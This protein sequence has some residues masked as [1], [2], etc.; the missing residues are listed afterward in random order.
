[1]VS[2]FKN[3][4]PGIFN[5]TVG[6]LSTGFRHDK[7]WVYSH[8]HITIDSFVLKIQ[9]RSQLV[10][11]RLY[12]CFIEHSKALKS[13]QI[14]MSVISSVPVVIKVKILCAESAD[15]CRIIFSGTL[16]ASSTMGLTLFDLFGEIVTE[17]DLKLFLRFG[18]ISEPSL[19]FPCS[20]RGR[21]G[22]TIKVKMEF[23][24]TSQKVLV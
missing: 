1:M 11:I 22:L 13:F 15:P 16:L 4:F 23:L 6:I 2:D 5:F 17:A 7:S 24:K 14:I 18:S 21:F 12:I 20:V 3:P 10:W 9:I 8:N 19:K